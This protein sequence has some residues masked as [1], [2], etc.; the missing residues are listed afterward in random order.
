M[1][2]ERI[3]GAWRCLPAPQ[4]GTKKMLTLAIALLF[5]A[6]A[7]FALLVIIGMLAGNH[8]AILSALAGQGAFAM[9]QGE[10]GGM[11][12][13]AR[14]RVS[15]GMVRRGLG[16]PRGGVNRPRSWRAAA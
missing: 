13:Q 15:V 9:A 7:A 10:R 2:M 14:A 12:P 6:G 8:A 16:Q 11:P 4:E 3:Q 1:N 5:T